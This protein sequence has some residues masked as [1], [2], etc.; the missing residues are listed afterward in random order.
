MKLWKLHVASPIQNDDDDDEDD[1]DDDDDD[2]CFDSNIL[3][4]ALFHIIN[5]KCSVGW[6]KLKS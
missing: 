5:D 6:N 2:E 1:D 4:K 3:C